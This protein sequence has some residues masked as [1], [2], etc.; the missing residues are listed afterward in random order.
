MY[1]FTTHCTITIGCYIIDFTTCLLCIGIQPCYV[2]FDVLMI[3]ET[4]LANC[5]LGERVEHLNK[6]V[7]TY[8]HSLC[9]S[10]ASNM[11]F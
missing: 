8:N 6:Y 2:V 10:Y 5:P 11:L 4:N 9:M 7:P 1:V 3:N